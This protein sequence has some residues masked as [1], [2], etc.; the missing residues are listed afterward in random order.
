MSRVGTQLPNSTSGAPLI[1][2]TLQ[3]KCACGNHGGCGGCGGKKDS[4][5]QRTAINSAPLSDNGVPPVVHQVLGS[6]GQPLDTSTRAFMEPRFGHDFSGVRVHTGTQADESARA[7]NAAAYTVGQNIVFSN[8]MFR[9]SEAS[10]RQLLAH[11]LTHVVQQSGNSK[12]SLDR[13]SVGTADTPLEAEADRMAASVMSNSPAN[14]TASKP[15]LTATPQISRLSPDA[16]AHTMTLGRAAR[17]GLQFQPTNVTDTQIGVVT[18]MGGLL[19]EGIDR[20][21]VI[22][23]ENLTPRSMARMLLPLWNSAFVPAPAGAAPGV[24]ARA[25]LTEE[26]LAQG[27]M[28]YNQ[29]YLGLPAMTNWRAGLNFPLPAEIDTA[30]GMTTVNDLQIVALATAFDP[31]WA[32][33]LD[34]RAN[35]VAAVPPA[36]MTADVTA[37]LAANP[38]ALARGIQLGTRASTNPIE[39]LPFIIETFNQLGASGSDVALAFV[40][41]LLDPA[42]RRIADQQEG[43]TILVIVSNA[44]FAGRPVLTPAQQATANRVDDAFFRGAST[45]PPAAARTQPLKTITVD[46]IKLDGST[47]TPATDVQVA[48]AI[49]SQCNVRV[50]HGVDA[51]A[52][53]GETTTWLNGNTDLRAGNNCNRPSREERTLFTGASAAHGFGARFRAFFPATFTGVNGSGYSCIP[54][55]TPHRL[56]RN[57]A[58]IQNDADTDSLAHELG[59]ILIN[60]GPHTR[61]G[62][63]SPRPA[64][65]AWRVDE[66]SDRHCTR[67][68]NNA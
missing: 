49:L 21:S 48:S 19:S 24:A 42:L 57:T 11:E 23:G 59:H 41:N 28:V 44:I 6:S 26:Q 60:L 51:T 40:D 38:T 12:S 33:L 14:K 66:I 22:V 37:F 10:G 65:P 8:R 30:T 62:L 7:V 18:A 47:H 56:L 53:P 9:P 2:G 64:A 3:R 61:T 52:R 15:E 13:L 32:P 5:L 31:A 27:L 54:S 63:M 45:P 55:D 20:L 58:V 34:T 50:Q 43:S 36:T 67:L 4:L 17:T 25:A 1:G 35:A 29:F 39:A 16:V 68:Y 46:T